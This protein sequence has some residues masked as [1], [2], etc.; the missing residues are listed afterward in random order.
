MRGRDRRERAGGP[1]DPAR[2]EIDRGHRAGATGDDHEAADPRAARSTGSNRAA[3]GIGDPP[4]LARAN[5]T[6]QSSPGPDAATP[7]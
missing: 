3:P 2:A 7:K 4:D 5:V 1:T 6:T